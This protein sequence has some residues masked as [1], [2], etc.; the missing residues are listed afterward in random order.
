MVVL[1]SEAH[2]Y[3]VPGVFFVGGMVVFRAIL[4]YLP[5]VRPLPT[6]V[7]SPSPSFYTMLPDP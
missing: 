7:A 5:L 2:V 3:H 1:T 6:C 4:M